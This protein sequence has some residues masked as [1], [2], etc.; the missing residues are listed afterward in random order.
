MNAQNP[1]VSIIVP[2]YN[3]HETI[4]RSLGSFLRQDYRGEIEIIVVDSSPNDFVENIIRAN[5][6]EIIYF[7]LKERKLP[8][9]ARNFGAARATSELLIFTDPD[10]YAPVSWVKTLVE[11]YHTNNAVLSGSILCHNAEWSKIGIH[12]CKFDSW[13]KAGREREISICPTAN[14]LC[15]KDVF[16]KTRNFNETE[17]L[18][19][20]MLSWE[21]RNNGERIFF[22]PEAYVYHDHT[23]SIKRFIFERFL[24]GDDFGRIRSE[25]SKFGLMTSLFFF[26]ISIFPIRFL[27]Q[28]L[29]IGYHCVIS[30][31]TINYIL[32]TPI[33]LIGVYSW[34]WGEARAYTRRIRM[35]MT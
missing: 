9:A 19:D 15:R 20:A 21:M 27:K 17:M 16:Q 10:I 28:Y 26:V 8:G 18:H 12:I 23:C 11:Y 35:Q 31:N 7:L 6:P 5:F 14:M 13:L 33:I 34:L 22:V 25:I 4:A 2:S 3:S 1:G 30:G 32:T 24:R 29:R